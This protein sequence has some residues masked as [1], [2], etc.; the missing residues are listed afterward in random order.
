MIR[1]MAS[2]R[3]LRTARRRAGMTQRQLAAASGIPQSTVARI[4]RGM[5]S[6]RLDTLERLLRASGHQLEVE[7]RLGIG[8]DRSQIRE[9]LRLSPGRRAIL[10][11]GDAAALSLTARRARS[12]DR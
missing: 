2:E 11:A 3:L 7:P 9:L 1:G 6:P 4:E 5:I 8:V 10:A 12:R